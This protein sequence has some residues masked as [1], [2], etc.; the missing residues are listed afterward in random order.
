MPITTSESPSAATVWVP[1]SAGT[2]SIRALN[3]STVDATGSYS[4]AEGYNTLIS[5]SYSRGGGYGCTASAAYS[6]VYGLNIN[7]TF[8]Y[9]F[10]AGRGHTLSSDFAVALNRDNIASGPS[11]FAIGR[12]NIASNSQAFVSGFLSTASGDNSRASGR[13]CTASGTY[14][15][16]S[17]YLA[18]ASGT[19]S[20]AE[21]GST[22]ASSDY[23]HAEGLSTTASGGSSHSEGSSTVASGSSAHAG[24]KNATASRWA[25]WAR[26]SGARGQYGIVS[27]SAFSIDATPFILYLD[28]SASKFTIPSNTAYKVKLECTIINYTTG[29]AIEYEGKGLIKNLAGTTTL[30]GAFTMTSVNGDAGLATTAITVTADDV[31]DCLQIQCTGIADSLDWFC[32]IS[33]VAVNRL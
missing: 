1:G 21:G 27:A 31:N 28:E 2:S 5:G 22:L 16:A 4:V 19:G 24:G 20:H 11:S 7:S 32:K 23:S 18:V 33:Y 29:D 17:N 14:S 10:G 6:F 13:Q 26:S 12:E 8:N 15:N 9:N 30:V 3:A 25:E